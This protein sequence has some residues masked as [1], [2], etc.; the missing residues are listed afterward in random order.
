MLW[1][2]NSVNCCRVVESKPPQLDHAIM[3]LRFLIILRVTF[4]GIGAFIE[5]IALLQRTDV[6]TE[7]SS[8]DLWLPQL[9]Q[10]CLSVSVCVCLC[11]PLSASVCLCLP[12]SASVCLCLPLSASVCL[13]LPLSASVCLC[14]P[15][16][17]SVCLCLPVSAC[18]CLCLPVSAC[19]SVCLSVYVFA[20]LKTKK[21]YET[22]F[23]FIHNNFQNEAILWDFFIFEPW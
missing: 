12:L 17:A 2:S 18:V 20:R 15:L 11:L 14:L 3:A 8:P 22:S 9:S 13:C 5:D 19:L 1:Q 16:S 4:F 21:F 23:I 10:L 7:L 6:Q